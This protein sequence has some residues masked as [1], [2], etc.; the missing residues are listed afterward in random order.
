MRLLYTMLL[1]LLS[2]FLFIRLYWKGRNLPD[3]RNR[4]RERFVW[5]GMP[6]AQVDVWI[7]AVS[8]G[9]VIAAGPLVEAL[10]EKSFKVMVT[11]MTPTG[12]QRVVQNFGSRVSHQYLPYDLPGPLNRF[13]KQINP[14]VGVI[15]ETELWPN[16]IVYAQQ[17]N[18]PLLL[19]NARISD[20]AFRQY[21]RMKFFFKPILNRFTLIM[22]QSQQDSAYFLTLGA[23]EA[24]VKVFGNM[25]FDLQPV[26]SKLSIAVQLK[27]HWGEARI[28]LIAA[29]TH[30]DEEAQL[31]Q[32]LKQLKTEIPEI[33]LLIAPRHPQ[34]FQL[35]S[36]L[37]RN[38]GFETAMRSNPGSV[39]PQSDVVILDSLG[40]LLGF[41]QISDYAFVGGSLVPIGGHNV[42][43]PIAMQ[44]PVFTG[45]YTHHS[46]SIIRDLEAAD[47]IKIVDSAHEL[48][49]ALL[50]MNHNEI[51]R[52]KQV[53]N[54][55]RVLES[56]QGSMLRHLKQVEAFLSPPPARGRQSN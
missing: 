41:Y 52:S 40:E 53:T 6:L 26:S 2:P 3:Y 16:L 31:L 20:K 11:T 44:V 5:G 9:E 28:V 46:K 33:L 47:A 4:I 8:L 56:N 48:A 29:S 36:E 38:A 15:M 49:Q 39:N 43:E 14:R 51:E 24:K 54:A 27:H 42:L 12:S 21:R 10:L 17:R 55:T 1:Y 50:Q 18:I 25:K 19:A 13:L 37:C 23:D 22:A 7:H 32:I 45:R 35:V 30:E 34:R